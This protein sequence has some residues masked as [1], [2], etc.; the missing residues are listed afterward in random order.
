MSDSAPPVTPVG[1][2]SRSAPDSAP[3]DTQVEEESGGETPVKHEVR[4]LQAVQIPAGHQKMVRGLVD[5]ELEGS[6]LMFTPQGLK[7]TLQMADSLVQ[8]D[9][10]KFMTLVVQNHGTEKISLRKG[11]RLGTVLPVHILTES[12]ASAPEEPQ[13]TKSG[14]MPTPEESEMAQETS[15]PDTDVVGAQDQGDS[16]HRAEEDTRDPVQ[17]R[18]LEG[19]SLSD[20][21]VVEIL[22]Q[23]NMDL[24]HLSVEEQQTLKSLLASY[25]DVFAFDNSELGTTQLVTHS[26]DTGDHRPIK[27]PL[28]RTPFALRTKVDQ[29]IEEMLDQQV[30][31]PSE[32]PWASPIVLVQKRDGGVRFCVDYRKLNRVTKLD[33]FPLP[34]IDDTLDR[35][36]GSRHFSTLDL[37]SGYWQVEMEPA[38]KE[39]TA[40]TTYSG[41]YQFRKMPF[42]LVNAPA[43]FQRLMEVVLAGLARSV[44]VVYLDDILVFGKTVAEHNSN[45]TQVL[46]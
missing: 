6:P 23:V 42:G 13:D 39:K 9:G 19:S 3:A 4:L 41:L 46:Q 21:R 28:R 12:G 16:T 2:E 18:R 33:E 31:E 44:C 5:V 25:V 30:I 20:P 11:L 7:E 32:S 22:S 8:M 17:V 29:L 26:I 35:L 10:D 40:F 45:L 1:Q 27:Q 43:T 15:I 24:A 37:A 14:D 38:S 34:R 36:T